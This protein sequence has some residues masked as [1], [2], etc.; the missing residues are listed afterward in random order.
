MAHYLKDINLTN[1]ND[2]CEGEMKEN[3]IKDA[4]G[5]MVCNKKPGNDGLTSEF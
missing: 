2:Q 3:E 1:P 5:N 4:L